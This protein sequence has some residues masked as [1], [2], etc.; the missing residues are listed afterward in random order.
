MKLYYSPGASSLSPHIVLCE[1]GIPVELVKVDLRAKTLPDGSDYTLINPK[2][3]VPTLELDDGRRLT[4]GPAIV[5]YVADHQPASRLAPRPDEFER[6]RLQEWLNFTAS[7]LHK[8]FSPLFNPGASEDW[9]N[10]SRTRL[11]SRFD[12]LS[13]QLADRQFVMGE[14]FT[15]ADAYLFTVLSWARHVKIDLS[16]WPALAGYVERVRARPAVQEAQRAEGLIK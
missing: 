10:A 4:E 5:Q 12:W 14:Q 9:K 6:Y 7:E 15:V 3:Y 8:S 1:A 11:E 16:R 2:G 13:S